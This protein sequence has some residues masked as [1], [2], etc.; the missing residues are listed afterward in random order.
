MRGQPGE[1]ASVELDA[2]AGRDEAADCID[3]GCL[4]C[5]VRPDEADEPTGAD[6][7]GDID[8]RADPAEADGDSGGVQDRIHRR[9]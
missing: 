5:A 4:A 6:L 1:V 2:A 9:A 8:D 3:E 7:E